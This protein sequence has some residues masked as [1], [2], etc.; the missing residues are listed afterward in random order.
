MVSSVPLVEKYRPRRLSEVVGNEDVKDQ[1][2]RWVTS[3][4]RGKPKYKA[5]LL[6][7]PPGVGKTSLVYAYAKEAGY[8]VVEVNASDR[9][10]AEE[11]KRIVGESSRQATLGA[12]RKRVILV[13]EVDGLVGHEEVGGVGALASIIEK[14]EVPIVMVANDPWSPRLA[15]LRSRAEMMK[16]GKISKR[17]IMTRL[18]TIADAEGIKVSDEVLERLAEKA[19]GDLRSAINDM[20]ALSAGTGR[21]DPELMVT[22]GA[23]DREKDIFEALGAIFGADTVNPG[24][25]AALNLDM[26]SETLFTWVFDNLFTQIKDPGA[27]AEATSFLSEADLH[28][29]RARKRR[30]WGLLKYGNCILASAPGIVKRR[31]GKGGERFAFPSKIRFMQE[32]GPRRQVMRS[33]LGK[34]AAKSHMSTSKA[35]YHMLPYLRVMVGAGRLGVAEFY[36]LDGEEVK[37]LKEGITVPMRGRREV[38]RGTRKS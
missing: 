2:L 9:R 21:I 34:I 36:E 27:I 13:D 16:F 7:G 35:S 11:I 10:G 38:R 14:T 1:F 12:T 17:D 30:V 3:W 33:I 19:G 32:T 23:R 15:A 25:I 37:V 4:S 22:L 31:S 20:E 28:L 6:V 8:E 24:R 26:D 5:A 29:S 18:R